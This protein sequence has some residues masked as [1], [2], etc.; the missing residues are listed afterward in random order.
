MPTTR[1]ASAFRPVRRAPSAG[2]T[3]HAADSRRFAPLA[4]DAP[5][6]Q[7][8]NCELPQRLKAPLTRPRPF[9]VPAAA[10]QRLSRPV[11]PAPG[12]SHSSRP[13]SPTAALQ[14]LGPFRQ[15]SWAHHRPHAA[16]APR[17]PRSCCFQGTL[18]F[19]QRLLW[20]GTGGAPLP[21][22]HP[23]RS[24]LMASVL[25]RPV[26]LSRHRLTPACSGLA[27][28]RRLATDA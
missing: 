26:S 17:H 5:V 19:G 14:R 21:P 1:S 11:R 23:P 13:P 20:G 24:F 27:R 3:R 10:A 16:S 8:L 2:L 6:R 18:V 4:A 12:R 9:S 28:L 15:P 22:R 7:C 25:L